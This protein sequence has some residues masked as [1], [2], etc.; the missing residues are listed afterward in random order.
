MSLDIKSLTAAIAHGP[1]AALLA[2]A[3]EGSGAEFLSGDEQSLTF[4]INLNRWALAHRW[5]RIKDE[6]PGLFMQL[7]YN[8]TLPTGALELYYE[9]RLTLSL[10][11]GSERVVVEGTSKMEHCDCQDGD[12][13]CEI[14]Q[15]MGELPALEEAL[16]EYYQPFIALALA[17]LAV[18]T[19]GAC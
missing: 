15:Q 18:D 3:L 17:S 14:C 19:A 2:T 10:P 9:A 1:Q 11:D 13:G 16:E 12:D 5:D 6:F 8:C 4:D 7:I